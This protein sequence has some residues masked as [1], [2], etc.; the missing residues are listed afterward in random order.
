MTEER[1]SSTGW[2]LMVGAGVIVV[3]GLVV[4]V[5][6]CIMNPC[7]PRQAEARSWLQ[8]MRVA[9][10]AYKATNDRYAKDAADLDLPAPDQQFSH[11]RF[12]VLDADAD[13]FTVIARGIKD[14]SGDVWTA[15][16]A[17]GA[18]NDSNRCAR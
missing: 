15:T 2:W 17:S 1:E 10:T 8:S 4:A 16:E 3:V 6:G 5:R 18:K 7:L 14:M 11:Y 9:Q 13:H 12:E